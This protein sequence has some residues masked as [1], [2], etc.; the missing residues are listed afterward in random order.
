MPVASD[1]VNP[2]IADSG[3]NSLQ[4]MKPESRDGSREKTDVFPGM[5]NLRMIRLVSNCIKTSKKVTISAPAKG[6]WKNCVRN[7]PVQLLKP[8]GSINFSVKYSPVKRK[9]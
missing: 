4:S 9:S 8:P 6:M 2:V 3:N 5:L 7:P 1:P